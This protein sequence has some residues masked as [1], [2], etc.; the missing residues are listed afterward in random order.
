[1]SDFAQEEN[2]LL[3]SVE[4]LLGRVLPLGIVTFVMITTAVTILAWASW[5]GGV[6]FQIPAKD[7]L[8]TFTGPIILLAVS[9]TLIGSFLNHKLFRTKK[10]P[11]EQRSVAVLSKPSK[12][13]QFTHVL[14]PGGKDE[15]PIPYATPV[16]TRTM[17]D[18]PRARNPTQNWSF[19]SPEN[20]AEP[21]DPAYEHSHKRS[22]QVSTFILP[23]RLETRIDAF[24]F[25]CHECNGVVNLPWAKIRESLGGQQLTIDC[26]GCHRQYPFNY[27]LA[28][29]KALAIT[30]YGAERKGGAVNE[31]SREYLAAEPNTSVGGAALPDLTDK[32]PQNP[33]FETVTPTGTKAKALIESFR[34]KKLFES[35]GARL[36]SRSAE[37]FSKHSKVKQ[38]NHV[39]VPGGKDGETFPDPTVVEGSTKGAMG[40]AFDSLKRSFKDRETPSELENQTVKE[41][42]TPRKQ[43]KILEPPD[44][45]EARIDAFQFNCQECSGVVDLPWAKIRDGLGKDQLSIDCPSCHRQ[46]P[47][48]YEQAK[49]K[50][51]SITFHGVINQDPS[52]NPPKPSPPESLRPVEP[53]KTDGEPGSLELTPPAP[54][55]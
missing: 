38:F 5:L 51:L 26:P 36:Q 25:N 2:D 42:S 1:L 34:N 46:Y 4:A 12:V 8:S 41:P 16:K 14:V 53:T 35:L 32:G 31:E 52:E 17:A 30:F 44:Q 22:E 11:F 43:E 39:L 40:K 18:T 29:R 24:S 54:P 55:S 10:G 49:R 37:I 3:S 28:K 9:I 33:A 15:E 50:T 13:N 48:D 27:E 7:S 21:K 19:G 45:L 6:L 47:F 20:Q 23:D